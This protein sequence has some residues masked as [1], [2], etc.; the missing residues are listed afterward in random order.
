MILIS[1]RGNICGRSIDRENT[2]D[3]IDEAI[4]KGFDVEIDIWVNG[5][6]IYLGHDGPETKI[7]INFLRAR[8]SRLWCH[9]KSL[10]SLE[11][12]LTHGF[13]TFFHD[14]DEYTLTSKGYIWAHPKSK[15]SNMTICVMGTPTPNCLGWCSDYVENSC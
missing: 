9:A 2:P 8:E 1:H 7:C 4:D 11:F 3:Y 15:F 13:H 10:E 5:S 6:D 12:L 14:R